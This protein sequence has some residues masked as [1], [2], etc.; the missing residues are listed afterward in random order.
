MWG[1]KKGR[2]K[3][4]DDDPSGSRMTEAEL[5]EQAG[6]GDP[7][8]IRELHDRH[9]LLVLG[10]ARRITGDEDEAR[11]CAQVAWIR[12][13]RSIA[14]Y[15]GRAPFSAWLRRIAARVALQSD[16]SNRRRSQRE[17]VF[18]QSM[19]HAIEAPRANRDGGKL[20]A[21]VLRLPEGMRRVL[22][23]HDIEGFTH[24]EIGELLGVSPGTSKSQLFKARAKV[25]EMV[26]GT[27]GDGALEDPPDRKAE[28]SGGIV[29]SQGGS[30]IE[31]GRIEAWNT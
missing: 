14:S 11:D 19:E 17:A 26:M 12:A 24:E 25:R 21:A 2:E 3:A 29:A 9:A 16:R 1:G 8:A 30:G 22:V 15:E 27:K 23:L 28:R 4:G 7:R 6:V 18:S 5:I 31:R 20:E 13:F 10:V